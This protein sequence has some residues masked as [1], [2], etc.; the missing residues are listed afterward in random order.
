MS[1]HDDYLDEMFKRYSDD[2]IERLLA[3][4]VPEEDELTGLVSLIDGLRT[5]G[6][7]QPNEAQVQ[8]LAAQAAAVVRETAPTSVQPASPRGRLVPRFA[9]ATAALLLLVAMTG[10]A[11][12][13]D[14]AAPGDLLYPI[15][16]ALE[17]I[18]VGDGGAAERLLEA[19]VLVDRG[20]SADA[21]DHV[22]QALHET[23]DEEAATALQEAATRIRSTIEGEAASEVREDVADML[24]F[25]AN[26]EEKGEDFGQGVA[27]RA[28]QIGAEMGKGDEKSKTGSGAVGSVPD[29]VPDI[30]TDTPADD[31]ETP[32]T[33]VPTIP[34]TS[35]D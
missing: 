6:T 1:R 5:L 32:S 29:E 30:V 13:S 4:G 14:F 20:M 19:K 18:G 7:Y 2:E 21:L 26:A 27:E 9:G 17:Q 24:E 15:D 33:T 31:S 10:V 34:P 8:S 22:S 25:I 12:A 16:R 11:A 23:G 3:G 35:G 28:R